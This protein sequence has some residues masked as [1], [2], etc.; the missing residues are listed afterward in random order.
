MPF[1]KQ[2]EMEEIS[3]P[4]QPMGTFQSLPGELMKVGFVT[5]YKNNLTI[6]HLHPNEEQFAYIIEGRQFMILGQ[7]EAIVGPG[8]LI[9]TPKNTV[10]CGIILDEKTLMFVVKSPCG[11]GGLAQD[12]Q[13]VEKTEETIEYLKK[14]F[15]ELS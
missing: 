12:Y 14:K 9:H 2:T 5:Y 8:D 15:I 3:L 10:H 11:D 1:Y 6:P 13:A 4:E 7:E